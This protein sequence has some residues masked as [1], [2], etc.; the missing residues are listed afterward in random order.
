MLIEL[1]SMEAVKQTVS[2]STKKWNFKN[3]V[4]EKDD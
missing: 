3:A 1:E 2:K 4:Y